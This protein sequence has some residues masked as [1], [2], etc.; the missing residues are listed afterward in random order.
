MTLPRLAIHVQTLLGIGHISR[1]A[2]IA[3]AAGDAGWPVLV[4]TGL[5]PEVPADFGP[6]QRLDLPVLRSADTAFSGLVDAA[7]DPASPALLAARQAQLL[8][9]IAA[10]APDILL[11][12][13]YPFGRRALRA[14]IEALLDAAWAAAPRPLIASSVRDILVARQKPG[15]VAAMLETARTR[16]DAVLVHGD[17]AFLPFEAAMPE[18][19]AIAERLHYTGYVTA[20]AAEGPPEAPLPPGCVLV[21]MGG[22]A[23]GAPLLHAALEAW[24]RL[25]TAGRPW[26]VLLGPDLPADIA[27]VAETRAAAARARGLDVALRP[28]SR[29]FPALLKQAAL[30]VSLGG[31][32]TVLDVLGSGTPALVVPFE[33]E[34]ETEQ[35]QRAQ[36]LAERGFIHL[37]RQDDLRGETL[38]AA[39]ESAL[40]APPAP[41]SALDRNGAT[42]S[43][44]ILKSLLDERRGSR[45]N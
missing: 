38:L 7:G 1:I 25:G 45:K 37:L 11:V 20:P 42:A 33:T 19:T 24:E 6:A 9:G 23:M 13:T 36:L 43:V 31:Y 5:K 41:P 8:A 27:Q 2:A 16:F 14:E 18:A 15:R 17:P 40:A 10:F 35:R 3:R 30:S 22:G 4:A 21:S 39:V 26:R 34:K 32:N 29:R 12:E 44:A 28:P